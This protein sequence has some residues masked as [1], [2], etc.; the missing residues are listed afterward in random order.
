MIR[1]AITLL[2]AALPLIV[3]LTLWGLT[4]WGTP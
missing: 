3:G 4:L 2:P 1:R